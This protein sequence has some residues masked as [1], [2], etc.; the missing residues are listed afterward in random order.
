[1]KIRLSIC[2]LVI[3]AVI[4]N[5][6][7]CRT[8]NESPSLVV[9]EETENGVLLKECADRGQEYID[10]L[11]FIGES[12]TYHLKSR[13]V[14]SGGRDTKQVWS[15]ENGTL[16]LDL[17]TKNVRI[18]Y[19]ETGEK[20]TFADAAARAKP[21][22]MIL[23]FGLNGAVEKVKKGA[24]YYKSCYRSLITSIEDA[25]PDSEIILQS[26]FPVA[27]NMDMSNYSIDAK[28]LNEYISLINSWTLELA[29]EES[30]SYLNTA[31]ILKDT[32]GWLKNDFQNGDG[33]HLTTEAYVEIL[34]YIRTHG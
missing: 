25:S 2:L 26:A 30:L 12:T 21:K 4:T 20:I 27:R 33:H 17:S 29:Q 7:S 22:Y 31:E 24:D 6:S 8:S 9:D 14:L 13:G 5:L 34:K 11:I 18:I 10:S 16:N 19:P 15:P 1:M 28:T 3:A 32:D 23:T